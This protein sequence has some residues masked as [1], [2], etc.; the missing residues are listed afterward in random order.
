MTLTP[1]TIDPVTVD[2]PANTFRSH[3]DIQPF[4]YRN[5]MGYT[6]LLETMRKWLYVTLVPYLNTNFEEITDSWITNV[7]A[8]T[9]AVDTAL[10]AQATTIDDALATQRQQVADD[11]AAKLTEISSGA[12]T[13][14]NDQSI[15]NALESASSTA[16]A[17]LDGRYLGSSATTVDAAVNTAIE[18][19]SSNS[20]ASLSGLYVSDFAEIMQGAPLYVN[21]DSFTQPT[22]GQTQ[23]AVLIE[24]DKSMSLTNVGVSSSFYRDVVMRMIQNTPNLSSNSFAILQAGINNLVRYPANAIDRKAEYAAMKAAI[25][26]CAVEYKSET[27]AAVSTGTW[28]DYPS[29]ALSGGAGRVSQAAGSRYTWQAP[30]WGYWFGIGFSF[31]SGLG[32]AGATG[33]WFAGTTLCLDNT[34]LAPDST[35][36]EQANDTVNSANNLVPWPVTIPALSG[37]VNVAVETEDGNYNIA[38]AIYK[39]RADAPTIAVVLPVRPTSTSTFA[40][41]EENLQTVRGDHV[42]AIAEVTAAYPSLR[43]RVV[44]VD[45][46]RFG[47]DPSIHTIADGLHPN[48]AGHRVIATAIEKTLGRHGMVA[49]LMASWGF[50]G[51]DVSYPLDWPVL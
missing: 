34:E 43:G 46:H 4:T 21:G 48:N 17:Y 38:D 13:A 27:N 14:L 26:L 42:R 29:S 44:A 24:A 49:P 23:A 1:P 7:T 41:A 2:I 45:P 8:I 25:L 3:G 12:N 18:T 9:T 36:L 47:W 51:P 16:L 6:L 30:H 31:R 35:A 32:V 20:R 37:S 10:A 28:S 33:K 11:L 39:V 19:P 15:L 22:G 50:A 40:V 5:G